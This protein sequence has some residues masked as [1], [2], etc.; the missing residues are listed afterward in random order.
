MSRIGQKPVVVPDGVTAKIENGAITIKGKHGE[1]KLA[2][3]PNMEVSFDAAQK[4]VLVK[5]PDNERQ[6]RALHGLTR[7][8]INNMVTGVTTP[9]QKKSRRAMCSGLA[10]AASQR[11]S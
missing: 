4:Q 9:F 10:S 5:R 7:S 8:L 3:H 1:L 2:Y 11:G 6:N